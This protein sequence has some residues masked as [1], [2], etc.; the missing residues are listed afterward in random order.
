VLAC[1]WLAGAVL[2]GQ[3]EFV[4]TGDPQAIGLAAILDS[5]LTL[6]PEKVCRRQRSVLRGRRRFLIAFSLVHSYQ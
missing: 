3:Y 4:V 5:Y 6:A 1:G 2:L